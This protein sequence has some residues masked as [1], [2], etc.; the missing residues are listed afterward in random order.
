MDEEMI[1]RIY[2]NVDDYNKAFERYIRSKM[3]VSGEGKGSLY[4]GRGMSIS[5]VMTIVILFH[6]SHYRTF[7]S[8]YQ[9]CVCIH[10]KGY[11]PKMV[12]Y[13]RFVE[14]MPYTIMPLLVYALQFRKGKASGISFIDSTTLK[15]CDNH[16]IRSNKVFK[17]KAQRGKSSMGWFYGFKLHL[18]INDRGEILSFFL[19]AGNTDDRNKSVVEQMCQGITGKLFGDRGYIS[20]ALF[21]T[22]FENGLKLITRL[23][24]NMKNKLME[25]QD[26][27][28][29][30]KRGVIESVNDVLKN[31]CQ[32]EHTRHRS[33]L[34][35]LV[36][37]FSGIAAYSFLDKKPSIF[38]NVPVLDMKLL[39]A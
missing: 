16:R 9:E 11:F 17:D 30:R 37:L 7:K 6:L 4:P 39:Q 14:L 22:L 3:L 24:S 23:K 13:T 1:T 28:L 21:E 12:S 5:E 32:I 15:V 38:R 20:K 36:N 35:F 26:V 25:M 10:L 29:L 2:C 34:N 8:Y 18:V 19:T 27:L 33:P 31:T